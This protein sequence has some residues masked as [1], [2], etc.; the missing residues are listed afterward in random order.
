MGVHALIYRCQYASFPRLNQM[1]SPFMRLF[2]AQAP[3]KS[4]PV[5]QVD[6]KGVGPIRRQ[7]IMKDIPHEWRV[8]KLQSQPEST[9]PILQATLGD[10]EGMETSN[11][12]S[13]AQR[14]EAISA[15]GSQVLRA[16]SLQAHRSTK[17][18]P[19]AGPKTQRERRRRYHQD[20]A[21]VRP[22]QSSPILAKAT[23]RPTGQYWR[24]A[25]K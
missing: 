15:C 14:R 10:K 20:L 7:V 6:K 22:R 19:E 9:N 21:Q 16:K 5:P 2:R 8:G 23:E 11:P 12:G 4:H 24:L 13:Q 17:I 1:D 18:Y 3:I 25:T